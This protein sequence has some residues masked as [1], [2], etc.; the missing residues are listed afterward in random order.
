MAESRGPS[1][2]KTFDDQPND[3][4]LNDLAAG[5]QAPD[6]LLAEPDCQAAVFA[7]GNLGHLESASTVPRNTL[8]SYQ[9]IRPLGRG[10][11]GTVFLAE[12][13]KLKRRCAIKLLHHERRFD[14]A[15][16]ERFDREMTTVA[17]LSHPNLVAA[18]DAGEDA[19]WHYLVMEYLE[20]LD[21]ASLSKRLGPL[22]T[23]QIAAIGAQAARGLA[24]IHDAGLVHRDVK[25]SNIFL[26]TDGITRV[27]DLG[28]AANESNDD[29][30]RVT[31]VGQ[32]VG[33]VLFAAPEQIKGDE[34]LDARADLYGLG[35]TLFQLASGQAPFEPDQ[36]L[37]ALAI[38]KTSDDARSLRELIPNTT[39]ERFVTIVDQMLSRCR[40]DRPANAIAVAEQLEDIAGTN[41]TPSLRKLV[42]RGMRVAAVEATQV[43]SLRWPWSSPEPPPEQQATSTNRQGTGRWIWTATLG[44]AAAILAAI[45]FYVQTDKG[46]LVIES[47]LDDVRVK[48]TQRDES[49]EA[50]EVTTGA[51]LTTLRSGQ[52][53]VEL[54]AGG[55]H[56]QLSDGSFT[57][58]R[59]AATVI[60]IQETK[61][62]PTT[63]ASQ[64]ASQQ[65]KRYR[66]RTL[67][68][69]VQRLQ[70]EYDPKSVS[71]SMA[72][73]VTLVDENDKEALQAVFQVARRLGGFQ[74]SGID[75]SGAFMDSLNSRVHRMPAEGLINAI[76]L[77]LQSNGSNQK[78]E[79]ACCW[80]LDHM[81]RN[82]SLARWATRDPAGAAQLFNALTQAYTAPVDTNDDRLMSNFTK[83]FCRDSI[84]VLS[85]FADQPLEEVHGLKRD[86][87][88]MME[89]GTATRQTSDRFQDLV[90]SGFGHGMGGLDDMGGGF[91]HSVQAWPNIHDYHVHAMERLGLQPPARIA[92]PA[93]LNHGIDET[94]D[95][96]KDLLVDF[97]ARDPSVVADEVLLWL[98]SRRGYSGGGMVG[99]SEASLEDRVAFRF[100]DHGTSLYPMLPM[101]ASN[102]TQP[103]F[104]GRIF[105]QLSSMESSS[106]LARYRSGRSWP[107]RANPAPWQRHLFTN[108][109][110]ICDERLE[111]G[112]NQDDELT[113]TRRTPLPESHE[114]LYQVPS[115][116]ESQVAFVGSITTAGMEKQYGLFVYDRIL[117]QTRRLFESALKTAPA[118]SP[119][120]KQIAIA[121][122]AGYVSKY[123]LV[124]VDVAT[125][126]V[127]DL[128]VDGVG[129]AWSPDGKRIA[130]TTQAVKGGTWM[131]GVPADGTMMIVDVESRQPTLVGEPGR[132]EV[133]DMDGHQVLIR[134]GGFAPQW[135][136]SGKR[137]A[138][139]RRISRVSRD[140]DVAISPKDAYE[141][142]TVNA[143]GSDA[144]RELTTARF[145]WKV[146]GEVE[147]VAESP[148]EE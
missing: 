30:L 79:M 36:S 129:A 108:A 70:S 44:A 126:N 18:T 112:L 33:T 66:D 96:Q 120:G 31:T 64:D 14:S 50:I 139:I 58:L 72:A 148:D 118:W 65:E 71:E 88:G 130:A 111:T 16:R 47:P 61:S 41:E 99:G 78:S 12:H 103:E 138:W 124:I 115:P 20:G 81:N 84:C 125:G 27:L 15:W 94:T 107:P 86:L 46:T 2:V 135:S 116:D 89:Q 25:P 76:R 144:R 114:P 17:S 35:G 127:R 42:R 134:D 53:Q 52:Y 143:D 85:A 4:W 51:N 123:P 45:V 133:T 136:P 1:P 95:L 83:Q 6:S 19:G 131:K 55:D 60:K 10:G 34:T 146:D 105:T 8:G 48:I 119:D 121:N 73:I 38:A 104:A 141:T 7:A 122:A 93:L 90:R 100:L 69:W 68:E 39:D 54:D 24:A 56:V 9:L 110:R 91:S 77:E 75:A 97:I 49:V 63:I 80:V 26:A 62:P 22:P 147:T 92:I 43:E 37:A 67:S 11:M 32:M 106:I 23:R 109:G 140:K 40:D 5:N 3:S 29:D 57:I 21:L 87:R 142:W 82:R 98:G 117:K 59:G 128:G 101:I 74:L 13:E 137:L 102:T 145:E 132:N 28:L 113:K